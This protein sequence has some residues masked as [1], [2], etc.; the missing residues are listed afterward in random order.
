MSDE[1]K[2]TLNLDVVLNPIDKAA[3]TYKQA[4]PKT[5]ANQFSK[6]P[7]AEA[8]YDA[9]RSRVQELQS[10]PGGL[11]INELNEVKKLYHSM[12]NLLTSVAKEAGGAAEEVIK[13]TEELKKAQDALENNDKRYN[14]S[15]KVN[16]KISLG[17]KAATYN[18]VGFKKDRKT[19]GIRSALQQN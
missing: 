18:D 8:K 16:S 6:V 3:N 1:V 14:R 4:D 17:G 7:G 15:Q 12:I 5:G 19:Y 11:G 9:M 13:A 10:K 2:H